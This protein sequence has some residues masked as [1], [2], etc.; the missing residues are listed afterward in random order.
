MPRVV[1]FEIC[2]D[3]LERAKKFYEDVFGWKIEKWEGPFEYYMVYTENKDEPG[4]NG[5]LKKRD[6]PIDNSGV[7]AFVCTVN[8]SSVD[9][10]LE[11]ILAKGG[12]VTSPKSSVPGVGFMAECL[13]T[14]GNLFGLME[15]DESA[16]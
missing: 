14:E 5:G 12:K 7:T 6:K 10:Y 4:I 16:K 11:K 13:D 2:A 1:H 9:E 15:D 3:N 8:V